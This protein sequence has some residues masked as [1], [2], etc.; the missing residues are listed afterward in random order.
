MADIVRFCLASAMRISEVCR[1]GMG[2]LRREGEDGDRIRDRKHPQDKLGNDQ[3][4]PLLDATGQDAF[5][6]AK[7][8]AAHWARAFFLTA[9]RRSARTSRALSRS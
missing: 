7:A 9:V 8:A 5:K 4:V 2:G 6:I 3:T 1:L